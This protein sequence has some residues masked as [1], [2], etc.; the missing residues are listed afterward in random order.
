MNIKE[1]PLHIEDIPTLLVFPHDPREAAAH[2]TVLVYHGLFSRKE[3]V[4]KELYSLAKQGYLAIGVDNVGHGDRTETEEDFPGNPE[5]NYLSKVAATI[6]EVPCLVSRLMDLALATPDH[7]GICGISMGG[8]IAFGSIPIEPRI[9]VCAPVLGSPKWKHSLSPHQFPE[10]FS[11]IALLAQ[12]AARDESVPPR[13]AKEFLQILKKKF[14]R[15]SSR[16]RYQEFPRSNHFMEEQEWNE[17]W[18]NV[19]NWFNRYL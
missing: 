5:A 13:F 9:K 19:L 8:F 2:G 11:S 1:Q 6:E 15:D 4:K 7:L 14:S 12:N 10:R 17:L 16:L 3:E 18:E